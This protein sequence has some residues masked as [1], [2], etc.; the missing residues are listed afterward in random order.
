MIPDVQSFPSISSSVPSS[1]TAL[2]D[3][4]IDTEKGFLQDNVLGLDVYEDLKQYL[5][6]SGLQDA[7]P[8]KYKDL[9]NGSTYTV[10][11]NNYQWGGLLGSNGLLA[12]YIYCNW[13]ESDLASYTTVGIQASEAENSLRVSAVPSYVKA[14]RRFISLYQS[15]EV[16]HPKV[17]YAGGGYGIDWNGQNGGTVSLYSFLID[18]SDFTTDFFVTESNENTFGI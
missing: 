15:N 9:V 10:D 13:I 17:Y 12:N 3:F 1:L 8:Q 18:S 2:E 11:G 14:W 4:I 16:N 5:D 6:S 7:A